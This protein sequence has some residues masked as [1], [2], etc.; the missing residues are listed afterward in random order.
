MPK[1]VWTDLYTLSL[2]KTKA[3][4]SPRPLSHYILGK[5]RKIGAALELI[6]GQLVPASAQCHTHHINREIRN[7]FESS[8]SI[9][10]AVM[11]YI[12]MFEVVVFCC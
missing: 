9:H 11:E 1:T 10:I 2:G 8:W 7:T 4:L 3:V 12:D 5:M 6:L